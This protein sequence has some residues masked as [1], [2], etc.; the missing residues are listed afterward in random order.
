MSFF[1]SKIEMILIRTTEFSFTIYIESRKKFHTSFWDVSFSIH[2]AIAGSFWEAN[3][4]SKT[5]SLVWMK[6]Q[7]FV[8]LSR[9]ELFSLFEN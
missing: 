2:K 5:H 3:S 9:Y 8:E 1:F 7:I 6:R 4:S